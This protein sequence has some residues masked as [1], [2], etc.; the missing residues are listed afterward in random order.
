MAQI[1]GH[2]LL[3]RDDAMEAVKSAPDFVLFV[4]KAKK[5]REEK[6]AAEALGEEQGEKKKAKQEKK[7]VKKEKLEEND[8]RVVLE[9]KKIKK[10]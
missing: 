2:L 9:E 8:V 5:E 1:Q 6:I 7:Q 10:K 4:R 3:H